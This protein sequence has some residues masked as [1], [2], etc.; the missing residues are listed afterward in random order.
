MKLTKLKLVETVEVDSKMKSAIRDYKKFANL[1]E[2]VKV[3]DIDEWALNEA[4]C[5]YAVRK[6]DLKDALLTEEL[7]SLE[8][9]VTID[10][11]ARE[12][13]AEKEEAQ[14]KGQIED[15]LDKA[16]KRARSMKGAKGDFP[17]ILL[18]GDAGAGKT[19]IVNQW[20]KENGINLVY[21]DAK[22]MSPSDL[23]G[24]IARDSEDPKYATR[25]GTKE[26]TRSL[27]KNNSVL[28]LDEYNRAK[29][30]I[31]GALLT[32]VQ[33]HVVWDPEADGEMRYLPNFLFTVA[34]INP[35][36]GAYPGARTLDPAEKSRFRRVR[37]QMIPDEHLRYL[38][39]V[40][41]E[42]IDNA[43]SE[44][45]KLENMGRLELAKTILADKNFTYDSEVEVL[46]NQDDENYIPLNYRSFK[47]ALD[48]S[49]GT[50][51]DFLDLWSDFCNY[52]KKGLIQTILSDYVDVQDKAN[53]A[54][55]GGSKSSVFA[56]AVSNSE[57]LFNAFP[58]LRV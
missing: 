6:F 39:K 45:E 47:K 17:N 23:G 34:A 24:I 3:T 51:K 54:L 36:T 22:T 14:T 13:E 26:F 10:Q 49:D 32:L 29:P 46:D 12:L 9:D 5:K 15:A 44:E 7:E 42:A 27:D 30:E 41:T 50:K 52:K 33:D 55:K 19:A 40:Y 58:D 1:E 21:K 28:F 25:L 35:A 56:K 37:V 38:T 31:R 57:K 8:E 20:A 53:D 48:E 16:L 4:A 2:S 43:D 18:V 11:A